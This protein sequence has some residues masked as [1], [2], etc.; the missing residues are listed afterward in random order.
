M[1]LMS[2]VMLLL[3]AAAPL[4]AQ[5]APACT[6]PRKPV[7][8]PL[9]VYLDPTPDVVA[10]RAK[11][12]QIYEH[13]RM[14]G[15]YPR[16]IV[17]VNF[18]PGTTREQIAQALDLVCGEVLGTGIDGKLVRIET[19]GS[20]DALWR[21]IDALSALPFVLKADPDTFVFRYSEPQPDF[22]GTG[23]EGTFQ[24]SPPAPSP[25]RGTGRNP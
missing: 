24:A 2:M 15:P 19:D 9:P 8:D 20:G 23:T 11:E 4:G 10:I 25:P 5:D 7:P 6:A 18:R 22:S 17:E 1:R 12:N 13:P 14:A 16:N 21:A 3:T